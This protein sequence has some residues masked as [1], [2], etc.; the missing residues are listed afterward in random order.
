MRRPADSFDEDELELVQI[1]RTLR[2]AQRVED[3]LTGAGVDYAVTVDKYR[4]TLLFV[5]PTERAGAFFHVPSDRADE[6][7]GLLRAAGFQVF[8]G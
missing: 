5:I 7:R 1:S 8:E 4:A 2:E 3:A 6:C